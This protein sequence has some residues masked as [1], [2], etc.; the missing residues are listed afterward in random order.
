MKYKRRAMLDMAC[1]F[2]QGA[3]L[4]WTDKAAAAG[5]DFTSER[6]DKG[7]KNY[8][9]PPIRTATLNKARALGRKASDLAEADPAKPKMITDVHIALVLGPSIRRGDCPFD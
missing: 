3:R 4:P 7:T 8:W 6:L 2:G 9:D 5:E 1:A